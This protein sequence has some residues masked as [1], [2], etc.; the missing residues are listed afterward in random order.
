MDVTGKGRRVELLVFKD[1]A[2]RLGDRP[3]R[4]VVSGAVEEGSVLF[5]QGP[6]GAGKSTLLRALARLIRREGGEMWLMGVPAAQIPP[7]AWRRQVHYFAQRPVAFEA[8]VVENITLS[9]YPLTSLKQSAPVDERLMK[10]SLEELLLPPG[11]LHQN[12]RTLSGGELARVAL[13]RAL[14]ASPTVL[15]LDE[16]TGALD[17]QA[18]EA[19]LR[20]LQKWLSEGARRGLVLVSHLEDDVRPFS[21]V[22]TLNIERSDRKVTV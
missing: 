20:I 7:T 15:L 17:A 19:V 4:I 1:L 11:L 10:Q 16:P 9:S 13:L 22:T 6:S 14:L 18:R 5:V 21:R 8:T 3:D 12:A 2:Y